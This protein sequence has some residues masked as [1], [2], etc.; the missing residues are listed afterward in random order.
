[1]SGAFV[2]NLNMN[3][4]LSQSNFPIVLFLFMYQAALLLLIFR[5]DA[6]F[7]VRLA[8]EHFE[9]QRHGGTKVH[10]GFASL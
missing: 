9:P 1:M 10:E 2:P 6:P 7:I 8:V 3:D 4:I 5:C